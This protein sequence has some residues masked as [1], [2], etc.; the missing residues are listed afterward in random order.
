MSVYK[1]KPG[2]KFERVLLVIMSLYL[3]ATF[4]RLLFPIA[5]KSSSGVDGLRM[6]FEVAMAVGVIGLGVRV[7]KSN[8]PGSPGKAGWVALM[9]AGTIGAI[10]I[11]GIRLSGGPRVELPPRPTQSSTESSA[12]SPELEKFGTRMTEVMM[13]YQKAENA[14]EKT[15]WNETESKDRRN[16]PRAA[17]QD[18]L[19]R[20]REYLDAI[21]RAIA[22]FSEPGFEERVDRLV[23]S[24]KAGGHRLDKPDVNLELW[25]SRRRLWVAAYRA[26]VFVEANWDEWVA[27]PRTRVEDAKP[28]Q[29]ELA[30]LGGEV[31]R[32]D[33]EHNA[34]V[35]KLNAAAVPPK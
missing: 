10:G 28:W 30:A 32:A 20:H 14:F 9:V 16:L 4:I 31:K 7:L 12:F 34:L 19:A 1:S 33:E 35:Q 25:Q 27:N 6:I 13:A 15:R 17:M 26:C 3:V 29:F 11:F 8:P 18:H 21:D 5:E 2:G 22:L 24:A 23:A